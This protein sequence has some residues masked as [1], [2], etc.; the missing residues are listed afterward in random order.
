MPLTASLYA[1]GEIVEPD[2]VL[3]D[4]GTGYYVEKTRPA[5][6]DVLDRKIVLISKNAEEV[7]AMANTKH[8]N[9]QMIVEVMRMRLNQNQQQGAVQQ[10]QQGS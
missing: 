1:P 5:A 4:I 3:V 8:K 9:L 7:Q 2:K 10:Q 6:I